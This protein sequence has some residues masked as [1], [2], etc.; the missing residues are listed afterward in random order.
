MLDRK[1]YEEMFQ[2]YVELN[3]LIK[4]F[5]SEWLEELILRKTSLY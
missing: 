5:I 2:I 4:N 1:S 3:L